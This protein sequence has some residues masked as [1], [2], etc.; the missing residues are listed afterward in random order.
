MKLL[1]YSGLNVILEALS[2]RIAAITPRGTSR[3]RAISTLQKELFKFF[4]RITREET[5]ESRLL[6]YFS[7]IPTVRSGL[8]LGS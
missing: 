7:V 3:G 2:L 8:D 1:D 6:C 5:A 4:D